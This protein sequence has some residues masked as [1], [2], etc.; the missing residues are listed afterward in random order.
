MKQVF[1][2]DPDDSD[3]REGNISIMMR[4][5]QLEVGFREKRRFSVKYNST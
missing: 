5:M 2:L 1:I 4:M 3:K